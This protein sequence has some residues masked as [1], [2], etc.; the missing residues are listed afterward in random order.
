MFS[1]LV[2]SQSLAQRLHKAASSLLSAPIKGTYSGN[3]PFLKSLSTISSASCPAHEHSQQVASNCSAG[4]KCNDDT[5]AYFTAQARMASSSSSY[6][7]AQQQ[8]QQEAAIEPEHE[9]QQQQQNEDE[10]EIQQR[11]GYD[12][13]VR[14]NELIEL[15]KR[16]ESYRVFRRVRRFSSQFP[17][18]LEQGRPVTIWCSN[19]YFGMSSHP[20]VCEAIRRALEE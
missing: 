15:K 12:Y 1:S 20:R 14:L 17:H 5:T 19:D 7:V 4:E 16:D 6:A 8:Q 9:I 13:D 11:H 18:G 3:C 2:N 10:N